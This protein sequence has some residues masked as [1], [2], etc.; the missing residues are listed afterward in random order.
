MATSEQWAAARVKYEGS[1]LSGAKIADGMGVSRAALSKHAVKNGWVKF[2]ANA[3]DT[4]DKSV[5]TNVVNLKEVRLTITGNVAHPRTIVAG[6]GSGGNPNGVGYSEEIAAKILKRLTDGESLNSIC[7]DEGYPDESAVRQWEERDHEGFSPRYAEA[8]RI[9]YSRLAEELLAI[10][11]APPPRLDNGATD[12]GAVQDKRL[13]VDTRK[14][15]L[16][17]VLPKIYGDNKHVEFSGNVTQ[18]LD[19][20]TLQDELRQL[21]GKGLRVP[22]ITD[23]TDVEPKDGLP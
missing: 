23:V 11:D 10:T 6:V 21:M 4:V 2:N 8:R 18:T 13:R 14:W 1:G 17:K 16:S 7:Q 15:L 22:L 5:D 19:K 9:G 20:A 12:S 3:V